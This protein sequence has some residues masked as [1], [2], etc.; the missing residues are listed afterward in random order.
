MTSKFQWLDTHAHVANYD[1]KGN[2]R[3]DILDDLLAVLDRSGAD[4]RLVL[5]PDVFWIS[6]M[7]EDPAQVIEAN[8]FVHDLVR[9]APDRLYGAC[10]INPHFMDESREAMR[11]CF[12]EWGFPQFGEVLQYMM[13]YRLN[14]DPVVE[15]TRRAAAYGKP[16]QVHISTSNSGP[17][18]PFPGGGTEQ[19][20]DFMDLTEQVPEANYILAHL[21]GT[22]KD[23]PPVVDG[24]LDQI[25]KRYG[26]L[27]E[28]FWA[29]IRDFNSPGVAAA[30]RRIPADKLIA[31]TDWVTRVGPP[32]LPYGTI[33]GV[34]N[35][36]ENPHAPGV[37]S[38]VE[39]LR[40]A[41]ATDRQIADIGFGNAA[42][43]LQI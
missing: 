13:D 2:F 6:R 40:E 8:R 23:D 17:Q 19:L 20:E 16:V 35:S 37:E 7:K 3:G 12:E 28:D 26:K 21:I 33:F 5:S 27:P 43:L 14:W 4:L 34:Q 30:L 32:Y 29:E 42:R 25:E 38:M 31:G 39:F 36:E 41:G 24:Y 18:G 10:T 11:L 1:G 15:L 22:E 9:R